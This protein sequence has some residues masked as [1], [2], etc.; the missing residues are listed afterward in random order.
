[1]ACEPVRLGQPVLPLRRFRYPVRRAAR[2][3]VEL[4]RTPG[5]V[6]SLTRIPEPNA[7]A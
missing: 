4:R 2:P 3:E 6:G 7:H 1:M 5:R